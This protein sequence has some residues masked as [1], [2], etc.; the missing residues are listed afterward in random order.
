L[1]L[2][3]LLGPA[4]FGLVGLTSAFVFLVQ[5]LVDQG[6]PDA[7]VQRE[8]L[9][10]EHL[11][12]AFWTGVIIAIVLVAAV[13]PSAHFI[14]G[15]LREPRLTPLLR[16]LSL[17][18][19]LTAMCNIQVAVL[20][21]RLEFRALAL[22]LLAASVVGGACGVAF[23]VL[24]YGAMSLVLQQLAAAVSDVVLLWSVS[25][26]RPRLRFSF[27]HLRELTGFSSHVFGIKILNVISHRS[28][29]LLIGYFLGSV[30][31]GYYTVAYRL[32][33]VCTLLITS[34]A[35]TAVFSVFSRLRSDIGRL[36]EAFAVSTEYAMLFA[37][38]IF[39]GL[40]LLAPRIVPILYGAKW[41]AS[42]P[43]MQILA[44]V[45][46]VHTLLYL[47]G[48]LLKAL[49]KPSK[50]LFLNALV[51]AT[52]VIAFVLVRDR[53]IVAFTT[54]YA[55]LNVLLLPLILSVTL[56]ELSLS[57]RYYLKQLTVPFVSA[58][59]MVGVIGLA[60]SV[61][62]RL[63]PSLA[64]ALFIAAGAATYITLAIRLSPE[65]RRMVAGMLHTLI[66]RPSK[67]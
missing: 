65:R 17:S 31:L 38:P 40:S 19:F 41:E 67:A 56:H 44:W 46:I 61:G 13:F 8:E 21:R 34:T 53:G 27:R 10:P 48:A 11:D 1:V 12:S 28:D 33:R 43:L 57:T 22:R 49:G 15:L 58:V 26:W 50:F 51:A 62:P 30:A 47:N 4:D 55:V 5:I 35:S 60:M 7:L 29:D 59:A 14:A 45:G 66:R 37:L 36:R 6:L 42:I 54:I 63:S 20:R 2:A 9:D 3:R 25:G 64:L 39:S 16:W 18:F 32:L 24:G 52:N 23:A